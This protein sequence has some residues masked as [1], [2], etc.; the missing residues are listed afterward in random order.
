MVPV[1]VLMVSFTSF[2]QEFYQ[3]LPQEIARQSGWEV[4][5]LVPPFWKELWSGGIKYL[6]KDSD[7]HYRV[8]VGDIRFA[9]N[10]HLAYFRGRLKELLREFRPHIVDLE[11]EPFNLGSF[12]TAWYVKRYLPAAHLVLHASQHRFKHYPL[13]FNWVEKYVLK[14]TDAILARNRMAVEVLRKKGFRGLLPVVTHGVDTEVFRPREDK[15]P[16][17]ELNPGGKPLVGFVGALEEHKGIQHL[18]EAVKGLDVRVVLVGS[19][20]LQRHLEAQA[21]EGGVDALFLPP[22]SHE[23]V[24]RYLSCLDVFVLPSLTRPNWVEKFGRVLIEAMASGVPVVGSSSGEIPRVV[25]EGGLIFREGEVADLREKLRRLLEDEA[26]RREIG[27]RGRRRAETH[28]SWKVIA[29]RTL[30]VYRQLLQQGKEGE[31]RYEREGRQ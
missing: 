19:G 18:L 2:I 23:E 26:L 9:G 21:R 29:S 11:N 27:R 10:L 14:H 12:Q 8:V 6:E 1:R 13:P 4:T 16:C 31:H 30:A 15:T 5:V 22:A 20:S 25:G 3:T 17:R 24:A 28:Y 7:P